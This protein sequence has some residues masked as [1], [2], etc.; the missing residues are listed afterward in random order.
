MQK[1][2]KQSFDLPLTALF[3]MTI[4]M[5][6]IRL[7]ATDWIPN[8]YIVETISLLGVLFGL[9]LGKSAFRKRGVVLF[10]SFYSLVVIAWQMV[11]SITEPLLMV[12]ERVESMSER[13]AFAFTQLTQGEAVEDPLLFL[14]IMLTI[15]WMISLYSG[16]AFARYRSILSVLMP[17]LVPVLLIQY[18]DAS[19]LW[20]TGFYFLFGLLLLGRLNYLQN[21]A[22]WKERNIFISPDI[23][24]DINAITTIAITAVL[25]ISWS[26][27]GSRT[28]WNSAVTWWRETL[29]AFDGT[30]EQLDNALSAVES[31]SQYNNKSGILY[32]TQLTLGERTYQGD[33][34]MLVVQPPVLEE[35][36]ASPPRYYWR[37]RT[38]DT[39]ING[40]WSHSPGVTEETIVAMTD[41]A[42]PNVENRLVH[43]FIFINK[44]E[45]QNVFVT[46]PQPVWLSED[47]QAI[48]TRLPDGSLDIDRL[49][50]EPN[51]LREDAYA[52]R[53]A[54]T[55]PTIAELRLAGTSYPDWV[56]A[57]YLQLP[58]DLPES[59]RDLALLLTDEIGTPY[60]KARAVTTY[61]R[62]EITYS[63]SIPPAPRGRDAL[64][65]FLFEWKQ[66]YCNYAATAQVILLRAAGVPARMVVGF[67]EGDKDE[68]GNFVVLQRDAHAWPEVYFPDIGWVEFEPTGN[69]SRLVRPAGVVN[70]QDD[71]IFG[72]GG[73][74]P[75]EELGELQED[76]PENELLIPDITPVKTDNSLRSVLFWGM[77]ILVIVGAGAGIWYF[78]RKQA[79]VPRALHLV[80]RLY[81]HNN[82][83]LPK[84]VIRWMRWSEA[85][86]MVRTFNIIN[87]GLRW[88]NKPVAEHLT[89]TER[90]TALTMLLPDQ[91][92][93]IDVLLH[94]HQVALYTPEEG[95]LQAAQAARR[96]LW[97][98]LVG[99]KLRRAKSS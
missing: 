55:A 17:T 41:I 76:V 82:W 72:P 71:L 63:N 1:S 61:L 49:R 13:L 53:S 15:F 23:K 68:R 74:Q 4:F 33:A 86:Q 87:V 59:I 28:E 56:T 18:Y 51:L 79:I 29:Q 84:W 3:V 81:Q 6:S 31:E 62:S 8:L 37:M 58:V 57:R 7:V 44:A 9:A 45:A 39:Y 34:E 46:G 36:I 73:I 20:T 30:R 64:E 16:Y 21:R 2:A 27:P 43:E 19:H 99:K 5:A 50:A 65:W 35:N 80:F 69:Q 96:T 60:D 47:I 70:I 90:A 24:F 93:T 97:L 83:R 95:D 26:I 67:A 52:A 42:T 66:G 88:L 25:F 91:T 10:T 89:P 12:V 48:Y 14:A 32:G 40:G 98:H 11:R 92:E 94:E 38:Y 78:N 22:V 77:I 54:L 85:S 75:N